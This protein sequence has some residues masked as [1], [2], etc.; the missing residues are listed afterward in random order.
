MVPLLGGAEKEMLEQVAWV[1]VYG[2]GDWR[3]IW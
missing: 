2:V 1:V 3:R